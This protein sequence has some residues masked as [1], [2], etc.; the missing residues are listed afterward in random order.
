MLKRI[1]LQQTN[2]PIDVF[3]YWIR[4]DWIELNPPY[5]RGEVFDLINFGGL[6]QGEVDQD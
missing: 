3:E 2:R 1:S 4:E 5:Q 6:V